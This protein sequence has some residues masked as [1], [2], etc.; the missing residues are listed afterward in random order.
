MESAPLAHAK[1]FPP[2]Q[3]FPLNLELLELVSLI[4]AGTDLSNPIGES[5]VDLR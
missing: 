1:S 5:G 4:F 3:A 2:S